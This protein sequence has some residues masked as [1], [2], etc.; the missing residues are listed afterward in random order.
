MVCNSIIKMKMK[1]NNKYMKLSGLLFLGSL[2]LLS[3]CK[4]W[5]FDSDSSFNKLFRTPK[6]ET[7]VLEASTATISWSVVPKADYYIVELSK[8]SLQFTNNL[9]SFGADGSIKTNTT[10]L[11]NLVGGTRY[12]VRIKAVSNEGIPSSEFATLTFKTPTEQL[13]NDVAAISGSKATLSWAARSAVTHLGLMAAGKD[14]VRIDLTAAEIEQGTKTLEGLSPSTDYTVNLWNNEVKRGSKKFKTTENFPDGYT[15]VR[16]AAT[17]SIPNVL[18]SQQGNV[19]LVFPAGSDFQLAGAM[20]I[21]ANIS[22]IIFWGAS[23][24]TTA[25]FHPKGISA[26]GS[27][28]KLK[29]YNLSISNADATADYII[30]QATTATINTMSI[31]NCSI[32]NTRGIIRIQA[33]GNASN[34]GSME[35]TNCLA[36]NIGSYG[37]VN[38]K[39]MTS[40]TIGNMSI[41]KSTF[42]GINAGAVI[43]V[44]QANVNINIDQCTFYNVVNTTKPFIDVNKLETIFPTIKN[45]IVARLYN[46]VDGNTIKACSLKNKITAENVY[47]TADCPYTIDYSMGTIY[48]K[49]AANLFQDAANGNFKIKDPSFGG[50]ETAGD[51]RWRN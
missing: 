24:G 5:D 4:D 39:D 10:I 40:V 27:L 12:S 38:T 18:A 46:Y 31:E 36:T 35:I 44:S 11:N 41:S 48:D 37:V 19:V 23:D 3:S 32:Y 43:N 20:A 29:F 1:I 16:L 2:M 15:V 28:D 14:S 26:T 8:D 21:P 25:K 34:I 13:F 7:T 30:N 9:K 6:V 50:A 49:T 33:A 45:T 42:N 51:P 47:T 22:S 17:D